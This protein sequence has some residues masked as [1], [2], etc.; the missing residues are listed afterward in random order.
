MT[1]LIKITPSCN[2]IFSLMMWW[3]AWGRDNNLSPLNPVT[4]MRFQ[5]EQITMNQWSNKFRIDQIISCPTFIFFIQEAVSFRFTV[6]QNRTW[7]MKK[8]KRNLCMWIF[9]SF[10][11]QCGQS[12]HYSANKVHRSPLWGT[13][14]L[15]K[16]KKSISF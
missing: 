13:L 15:P 11:E 4:H 12:N 8:K 5:Q 3:L 1:P 16:Q 14:Y 10:N 9:D 6:H 2:N 7:N